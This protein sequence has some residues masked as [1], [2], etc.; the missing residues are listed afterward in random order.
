MEGPFRGK[1]GKV[2]HLYRFFAFLECREE[3]K[4]SGIINVKT[5]HCQLMGAKKKKENPYSNNAQALMSP[6]VNQNQAPQTIK[7]CA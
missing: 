6:S 3:L 4:N 7:V 2:V 1:Q 5:D